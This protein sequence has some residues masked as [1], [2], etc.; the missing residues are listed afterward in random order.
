MSKP[1]PRVEGVSR[2]SETLL[3]LSLSRGAL[4]RAAELRKDPDLLSRLLGDRATRVLELVGGSAEVVEARGEVALH[5]R[6]PHRGDLSALGLFLGRD[7]E[8]TSY[9][10]VVGDPVDEGEPREWRSLRDVAVQLS[11]RD[12]G[13]FT[14]ALALA[15]WHA[16]HT[17]CPRCGSPTTA[18]QGGWVRRCTNDGTEHYPRTDPAVI[19][20]VVDADDRLLLARGPQ[21]GEARY[22]VL[23]GFVEPGE[24]LEAAVA[25]EVHEEVGVVVED[26]RYLGNQPWPFPCSLMVGFT[27]TAKDTTFRLDEEEIVEAIWVTRDELAEGVEDGRIG[28]S[29]RL[30]I[31]RRLIEHWYGAEIDQPVEWTAPN[32]P[33]EQKG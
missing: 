2:S 12:S 30:S 27:A 16:K 15:N 26:V 25:R 33:T 9:V 17:H 20:S 32:R 24:S 6:P 11:D 4:D 8:G 18:Q 31:A 5:L 28:I 10:A 7:E 23:A 3:D 14:T 22:S 29:P 1:A 19:M 13:L 21:W